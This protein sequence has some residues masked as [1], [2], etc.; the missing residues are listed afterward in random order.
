MLR[1]FRGPGRPLRADRRLVRR[2]DGDRLRP[3][4]TAGGRGGSFRCAERACA[5]RTGQQ[6]SAE[7]GSVRSATSS[8]RGWST[9]RPHHRGRSRSPDVT[10]AYYDH[11]LVRDEAGW[12]FEA[13]VETTPTG[14][15]S[16]EPWSTSGALGPRRGADRGS[17]CLR[18]VRCR[19]RTARATGPPSR[20]RSTTWRPAT[21]SRPTSAD[22]SRPSSPV[23]RSTCSA[24]ASSG[25]P[26]R[27]PPSSAQP[28]GCDRQPLA[29]ALP[30]PH[31][32][33]TC[34]PRRSRAPRRSTST[35]T[36]SSHSAKDR[37]ENVMI[38]DLMRNDL[39]RVCVPGS[40][41]VEAIARAERRTGVW[42]L[43][44]DVVGHAGARCGR[45]RLC[46]GRPS[47]PAR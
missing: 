3:G 36:S 34:G 39:G 7:A 6:V 23:T 28:G 8:A 29:G 37:A 2:P 16:R 1:M 13:L 20:P 32:S 33:P 44:S 26:R 31:G 30:A 14:R 4:R 24:P 41:R 18:R 11:V 45:R 27:T 42:H 12:W 40:V 21:S 22:V 17:L 46:C 5:A 15:G 35:S 25:S 9:C 47:R 19:P 38:V 43:V 10:L